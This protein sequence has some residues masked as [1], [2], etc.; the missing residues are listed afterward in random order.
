M[1]T[2]TRSSSAREASGRIARR[3]AVRPSWAR[4]VGGVDARAPLLASTTLIASAPGRQT[5][6]V[7]ICSAPSWRRAC[8]SDVY[9]TYLATGPL[10]RIVMPSRA[11]ESRATTVDN[12]PC[13]CVPV[14]FGNASQP[15]LPFAGRSR[16]CCGPRRGQR[17]TRAPRLIASLRARAMRSRRAPRPVRAPRRRRAGCARDGATRAATSDAMASAIA[18]RRA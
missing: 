4:L 16:R 17:S 15:P 13:G 11:P 7:P 8:P 10:P 9:E 5:V 18:A 14:S 2:A 3:I 12:A 1:V 6:N